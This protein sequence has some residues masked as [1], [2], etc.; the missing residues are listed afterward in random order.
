MIPRETI[1][2]II[3]TARIEEVVGDFI[4][5]KKRGVNY[6]GHCPFHNEKTPSFT[7]SPAKGIYKCFGCSAGGNAVNF[8]MEHEH[9]SYPEALRYLAAKYHIPIE[10]EE[11][12]P[13]EIQEKNERE[14]LFIISSFAQRHFTKNLFETEEGKTI[15]LSYFKERGFNEA[16]IEKFQLGYA[17]DKYDDLLN[18]SQEH[19]YNPEFLIKTGLAK[20]KTDAA[21]Q[22]TYFDFFR[23][24][25]VF[26]IHNQ[27]GKVI[28]FGART[29]KTDKKIPKY[30]NSPETEIY[31]KSK[32][33]YGLAFA[34]KS[35][36]AN[37]NCYLVEG[38]TDVISLWQARVENVVASSGTSLT[39]EQIRLV[40]R[41]TPNITIL[42]D[43]DNAG[44]KASFRGIDMILEEGMNVKVVL[45][46][47]GDDPDSYSKKVTTDE[48][49]EYIA[50]NAKDFIVFK[51][52]LLIGEA[53]ADPVKKAGL[54]HEIVNSIALV[55]DQIM[56]SVYVKECA[57]IFELT[58]QT[59][60][61]ELNKQRRKNFSKQEGFKEDSVI[62]AEPATPEKIEEVKED[63]VY[64]KESELI[65]K[66]IKYGHLPVRFDVL[67]N[68]DKP[69]FD[70][71][72][73]KIVIEVSVAEFV[74]Y[75]LKKD[76]LIPENDLHKRILKDYE[77]ILETGVIPTAD[78]F[79]RQPDP[80]FNKFIV[81]II[82]ENY[83]LSD[84]W[85][86]K[87]HIYTKEEEDHLSATVLEILYKYK[88][89]RVM[90]LITELQETL[91]EEKDELIIQEHLGY[92]TLLN[93]LKKSFAKKLGIVVIK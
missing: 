22:T 88:L 28:A 67:D 55:P 93:E 23:D 60:I 33:L 59:L 54:I 15:G 38:Y 48:L 21:G 53:Q 32:T 85:K 52:N 64:P 45:F 10:E 5:L 6:I 8:V 57:K 2:R 76:N 34:K 24:R 71:E 46:P 66:M 73:N 47:D 72:N 27:T 62:K 16:T 19:G 29:L 83:H 13:Q 79:L 90:K 56:R 44:I 87:H 89:S 41:F 9:S 12:S 39:T 7:V 30:L 65:K 81:D 91:K 36:I 86:E 40:K 14:E 63:E 50:K 75:E 20:E 78:Y 69:V 25:V 4:S 51:T 61:N 37:D 74:L 68:E 70:E 35:I 17:L 58:E 84:K 80:E 82:A 18:A 26:P 11:L 49:H 43:G 1:D 31:N 42:Y 3:E 77:E 92:L